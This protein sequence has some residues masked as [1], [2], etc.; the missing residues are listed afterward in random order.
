MIIEYVVFAL[1]ALVAENNSTSATQS[2][3]A[4]RRTSD[5]PAGQSNALF[6]TYTIS[7]YFKNVP[8]SGQCVICQVNGPGL[9]TTELLFTL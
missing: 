7:R 2:P 8:M 4:T 1:T 9:A 3:S 5:L 6:N